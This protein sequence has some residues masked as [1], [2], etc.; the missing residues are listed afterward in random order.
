M[1]TVVRSDELFTVDISHASFWMATEPVDGIH[2]YNIPIPTYQRPPN[3]D[4]FRN[5]TSR[6]KPR[7]QSNPSDSSVPR[8]DDGHV[9]DYA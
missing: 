6:R 4:D 8:P 2:D 9:D 3:K 5:D 7:S 1:H